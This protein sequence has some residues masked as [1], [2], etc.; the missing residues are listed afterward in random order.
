MESLTEQII[1]R[2]TPSMRQQLEAITEASITRH[3]SD[4]V[5]AAIQQYIERQHPPAV[6]D[7]AG[8]LTPSPR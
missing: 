7:T 2:I 1:V 4:H 5:R 3:A 6:Q 8:A